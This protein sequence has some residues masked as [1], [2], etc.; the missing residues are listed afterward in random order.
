MS[1][2]ERDILNR[3]STLLNH[4]WEVRDGRVVPDSKTVYDKQAVKLDATYLYADMAGSTE[5]AQSID[6]EVAARVMRVYLDMAVRVIRYNEG[7]IRSFDGDRVMG[8][9]VGWDKESRA[10]KAALGIEYWRGFLD[11]LLPTRLAEVKAIGWELK[12]G[13]G[14]DTGEALLVRA[15]IRGNDDLISIGRAPNIAAKLSGLREGYSLYATDDAY[16]GMDTETS[17]EDD[18]YNQ[19]RW[20]WLGERDFGGR[21]V[22]VYGSN[23]GWEC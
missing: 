15:G 20:T 17:Y 23:Y 6:A 19:P 7:D 2:L 1:D 22:T 14:I 10:A 4:P 11:Y 12:H 3:L 13:V 21:K 5:L 16:Y 9:F 8:I 18:E